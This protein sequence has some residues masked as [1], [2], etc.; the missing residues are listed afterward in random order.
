MPITKSAIKAL[1]QAKKRTENN[2][3]IKSRAKTALDAMKKTPSEANLA[4]AFSAVDR[5]VKNHIFHKNKAG[6]LKSQLSK[7]IAGAKPAVAAKAAEVKKTV[8]KTAVKAEK[9]VKTTA[10]T[11]TKT[12]LVAKA[13]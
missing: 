9:A 11:A 4:M 13:K 7:L 1:K 10:K 6:H 5:A 2:R 12:V 8:E 3:A